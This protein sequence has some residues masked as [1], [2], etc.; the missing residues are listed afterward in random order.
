MKC[1][2]RSGDTKS[3]DPAFAVLAGNNQWIMLIYFSV[4]FIVAGCILIQRNAGV[5][6]FQKR[7]EELHVFV[8]HHVTGVPDIQVAITGNHYCQHTNN[9]I[10]R[11][12]LVTSRYP[13][14]MA[15]NTG[16]YI[17]YFSDPVLKLG[18]GAGLSMIA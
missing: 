2:I 6:Y 3:I 17:L 16:Y 9:G 4:V 18:I 15:G 1:K 8:F 12:L 10:H 13:I 14:L 7:I 5:I 11:Q